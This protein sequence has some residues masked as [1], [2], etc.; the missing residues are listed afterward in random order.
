MFEL[1]KLQDFAP[2][3]GA[4]AGAAGETYDDGAW[5]A[6]PVPGDVHRAL[7]AAGRIEDPFYDR[8]EE[9][10]AWMEEREWWYRL[11]VVPR[12]EP[13]APDERKAFDAAVAGI[14]E[15]VALLKL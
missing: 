2:G 13:L 11:R 8:N 9:H 1:W 12:E 7:I 15:N 14:R 3:E 4:A 5:I 6:V 10:C